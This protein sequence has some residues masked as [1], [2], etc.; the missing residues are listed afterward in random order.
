MYMNTDFYRVKRVH[1]LTVRISPTNCVK[2][3]V[4]Q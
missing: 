3:G 1:I 4:S 2:Y